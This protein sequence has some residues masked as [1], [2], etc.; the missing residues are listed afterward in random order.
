MNLLQAPKAGKSLGQVKILSVEYMT[1]S[2]SVLNNI[3][4]VLLIFTLGLSL[5]VFCLKQK[6]PEN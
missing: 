6:K 3:L 1:V 4:P 5:I 2:G